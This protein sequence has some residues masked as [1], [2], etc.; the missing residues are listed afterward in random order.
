VG[1]DGE[2]KR[3]TEHGVQK[4]VICDQTG[5]NCAGVNPFHGLAVVPAR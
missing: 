1:A 4:V 3:Y 2:G 5:L